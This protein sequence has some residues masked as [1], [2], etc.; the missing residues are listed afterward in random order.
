MG[1]HDFFASRVRTRERKGVADT[2]LT[3]FADGKTLRCKVRGGGE[4]R[5][6]LESTVRQ[7][8]REAAQRFLEEPCLLPT[9]P[10]DLVLR[11]GVYRDSTTV[12]VTFN[13]PG[14]TL[15]PP[16]PWLLRYRSGRGG[17]WEY[18]L[19]HGLDGY[20]S[21]ELFVGAAADALASVD[22]DA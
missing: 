9:G 1:A 7:K 13:L 16:I 10:D 20:K 14:D 19:P 17:R 5:T 2:A 8:M 12:D 18:Y 6:M 4:P 22:L 15:D 11:L 3:A 21:R